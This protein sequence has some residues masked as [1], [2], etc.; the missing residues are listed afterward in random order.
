MNNALWK[1]RKNYLYR[2]MLKVSNRH[3]GDDPQS[4]KEYHDELIKK[5]SGDKIEE[6]IKCFE[7]LADDL[8]MYYAPIEDKK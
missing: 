2:L 6:P 8:N 4:L 1:L 3:G 5:Y 7:R